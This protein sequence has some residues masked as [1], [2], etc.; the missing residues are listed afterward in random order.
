MTSLAEFRD[1]VPKYRGLSDAATFKVLLDEYFPGTPKAE[2][3]NAFGYIPEDAGAL[4]AAKNVGGG[5]LSG[6]GRELKDVGLDSVGGEIKRTGDEI[7]ADN[8]HY[9]TDLAGIAENPGLF[10]RES[11]GSMGAQV[12][13]GLAA[14]VPGRLVGGALGGAIASNVPIQA[15]SYGGN[16]AEQDRK[17]INKPELALLASLASVGVERLGGFKPGANPLAGVDALAGKTLGEAAK[18]VAKKAGASGLSEGLEEIPDQYISDIGGGTPVDKV[19]TKDNAKQ[20][21]FGALSAFP[22]GA[23]FG[24]GQALAGGFKTEVPPLPDVSAI[25]NAKTVDEAII[26]AGEVVAGKPR[27]HATPEISSIIAGAAQRHGVS[28]DTMMAIADIESKFNPNAHNDS[29]ASGLFQFMPSTAKAYGLGNP[30]DASDNADAAAR[31]LK[32][33]AAYLSQKLG[34]EPSTGE[35]YLAHQ[36]GMGGAVS[37]LSDPARLA[38]EVVGKQAVLQ[39]GGN[40]DM[41]AGQFAGLWINKANA[42]KGIEAAATPYVTPELSGTANQAIAQEAA[43]KP[44]FEESAPLATEGAATR[45]TAVQQVFD[46]M[47]GQQEAAVQQAVPGATS[48]PGLLGAS[49]AGLD[50]G[51]QDIADTVTSDNKAANVQ[52]TQQ[53]TTTQAAPQT[54]S[55]QA[56]YAPAPTQAQPTQTQHA[57]QARPAAA[58]GAGLAPSLATRSADIA[59]ASERLFEAQPELLNL[60]R[61]TAKKAK[62]LELTERY[63]AELPV[64]EYEALHGKGSSVKQAALRQRYAGKGLPPFHVA[65]GNATLKAAPSATHAPVEATRPWQLTQE[66]YIAGH[67]GTTGGVST[68]LLKTLHKRAVR[69]ALDGGIAVPGGVLAKYPGLLASHPQQNIGTNA[70]ILSDTQNI[71][72]NANAVQDT[73]NK[74]RRQVQPRADGAGSPSPVLS[75]ERRIHDKNVDD[76]THEERRIVLLTDDM[77]PLGNRRAYNQGNPTRHVASADLDDLK[78]VNSRFGHSGGDRVISEVGNILHE[79]AAKLGINAYRIGGDEYRAR[80]D[81]PAKLKLLFNIVQNRLAKEIVLESTHPDGTVDRLDGVGLSYG[82]AGSFENADKELE[83]DKAR[84]KSEGLRKGER[85]L[86]GVGGQATAG[87]ETQGDTQKEKAGRG[88]TRGMTG[89][90]A[91]TSAELSSI[92]KKIS[93][94]ARFIDCAKG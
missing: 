77:T 86:G 1:E 92:R 74:D 85:D 13:A 80:H 7:Q 6:V 75:W 44:F 19:F 25:A 59:A 55:A 15:Q 39:N 81:D 21:A 48:P 9:V 67:K 18:H 43:R 4:S 37:L 12:A 83:N 52:K 3:A 70:G 82:V 16:R 11:A 47:A 53:G 51:Q 28:A 62:V 14:G 78:S 79:E 5:I 8:P 84:R 54:P 30:F 66:E 23:L 49:L 46:E 60:N 57:P 26:G 41:T 68:Q 40:L 17:G 45:K 36:Q 65:F 91:E 73:Q 56:Q 71:G 63:D 35:L 87:F 93:S 94:L 72:T 33:N 90:S 76:M 50:G 89:G 32:D 24:G 22:G 20:A 38:S 42:A 34:R 61:A 10:L 2:V 27:G 64:G 29:G 88:Q 69:M 31:L 58:L